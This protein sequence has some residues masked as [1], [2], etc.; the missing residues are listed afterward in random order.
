MKQAREFDEQYGGTTDKIIKTISIIDD[1]HPWTIVRAAELIRW[2]DSGEYARIL[3]QTEGKMCP[4]HGGEVPKDTII[5]PVCGY[6][7]VEQ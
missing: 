6:N 4:V 3:S 7:F 2:V 1:D 5:C